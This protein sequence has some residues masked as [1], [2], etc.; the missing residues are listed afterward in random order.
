M[1]PTKNNASGKAGVIVAGLQAKATKEKLQPKSST[2]AGIL[3]STST[4]TEVQLKKV[5]A[6][7]RQGPKTTIELRNAGI[8]QPASRVWQL[9]NERNHTITSEWVTLYDSNGFLHSKCARYHLVAD[10]EVEGA[11]Q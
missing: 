7:L 1:A 5:M 8:M 4:S 9:K 3:A 6:L 11:N 2:D 10:A